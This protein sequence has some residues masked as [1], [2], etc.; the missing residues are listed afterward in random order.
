M[1]EP[2][3]L[4]IALTGDSLI[5]RRISVYQDEPTQR[6]LQLLRESDVAFTNLE[7]LPNNFQGYPVEDSGGSHLGA[8]EWVIDELLSAGINLF[9][10][11]NNHS[12]NY[13]VTG[14]LA[15]I[16]ILEARELSWAGVGRNLG[17]ARMPA[18]LDTSAGSVALVA[19]ASTFGKGQQASVQR[20]DMQG[21]PGVNPLRYSTTYVVPEDDLETLRRVST[22]LGLETRRLER[23]RLGFGF[24]PPADD[25]LPF[26]DNNFRAGDGTWIETAPNER[27]LD[28][29]AAWVEEASGRADLVVASIHAH[30]QGTT[31]EDPADFIRAFARRVIEA[32]ANVVVGHGPHLLRGVE[33]IDGKPV[34]YSLGNFVGQNELTYKLPSDSY[35]TFRIDST[36]TPGR[37]YHQRSEGDTKG[38]PADQRYWESVV[39]VCRWADGRLTEITIYPISLGL[40][41]ASHRRGRPRLAT[42]ADATGILSRFQALSEPFGTDVVIEGE[43]AVIRPDGRLRP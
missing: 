34:F 19:C 8:H 22:N 3:E 36:T 42:G 11:P 39:P 15:L 28:E 43:I 20:P 25:I 26:L 23:I 2:S 35:E 7:S 37:V 27:D 10:L 29:I 6:L 13:G 4:R 17:E 16:D 31:K 1:T 33:M 18:Y 41:E 30:E 32:G 21:R 9:A 12:L 5:A 40:G 14:L 24:P 38:F